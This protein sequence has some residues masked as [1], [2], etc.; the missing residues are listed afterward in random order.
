MENNTYNDYQIMTPLL[1][2]QIAK[3]YSEQITNG[4]CPPKFNIKNECEYK[5]LSEITS[6]IYFYVEQIKLSTRI[7]FSQEKETKLNYILFLLAKLK[8]IFDVNN[9]CV[10]K[11]S[12][13]NMLF[14]N[15]LTKTAS[16]IPSILSLLN[17]VPK[18]AKQK[19]QLQEALPNFIALLNCFSE[20]LSI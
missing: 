5:E 8:L 11:K 14:I 19:E 9:I 16:A 17:K 13:D 12:T 7:K 15:C 18:C 10:V 6:S 2:E 4:T 1:M 20:L 3:K